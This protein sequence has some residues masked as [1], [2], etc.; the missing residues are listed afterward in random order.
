MAD[1]GFISYSHA[2]DVRLAPA[3]ERGLQ[4]IQTVPAS[5]GVRV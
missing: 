3:L 1:D 4:T 2:A 5:E